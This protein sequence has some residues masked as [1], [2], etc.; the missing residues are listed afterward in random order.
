MSHNEIGAPENWIRMPE[1]ICPD[2]PVRRSHSGTWTSGDHPAV[3]LTCHGSRLLALKILHSLHPTKS[4]F[5]LTFSNE[6]AVWLRLLCACAR[7]SHPKK[8]PVG[9]LSTCSSSDSNWLVGST[10]R[11]SCHFE[12][13]SAQNSV[14]C[15]FA[16]SSRN[17]AIAI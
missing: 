3:C 16:W 9:S 5:R 6:C 12:F 4:S 17:C 11:Y 1:G 15:P 7:R 8:M 14:H 2:A 13:R 10:S